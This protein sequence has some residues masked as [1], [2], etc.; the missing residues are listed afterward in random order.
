MLGTKGCAEV[1][2]IFENSKDK[3]VFSCSD[4]GKIIKISL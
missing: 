4:L 3:I 2:F 1:G